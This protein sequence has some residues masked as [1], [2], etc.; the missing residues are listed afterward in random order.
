[1]IC[2]KCGTI[3]HIDDLHICKVENIP[4]KGKEILNGIKTDVVK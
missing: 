1:M 4:V 3:F 2:T